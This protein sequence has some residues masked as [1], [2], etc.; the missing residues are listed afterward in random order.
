VD[1][2]LKASGV[3][4]SGFYYLGANRMRAH[5]K[6][7][8]VSVISFFGF[9]ATSLTWVELRGF[10]IPLEN[11]LVSALLFAA[12]LGTGSYLRYRR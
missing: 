11:L 7:I 2:P 9:V 12:V 4:G 5:A 1:F 10:H 3:A 6:P 8:V